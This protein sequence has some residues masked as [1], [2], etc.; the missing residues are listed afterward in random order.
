MRVTATPHLYKL[1]IGVVNLRLGRVGMGYIEEVVA[2]LR[3]N[4]KSNFL[5]GL[6]SLK[7]VHLI[8][9]KN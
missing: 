1:A 4:V 5:R 8:C 9:L 2:N 6:S 7:H 3:G